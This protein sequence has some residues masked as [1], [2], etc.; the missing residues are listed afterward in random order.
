LKEYEG[1]LAFADRSSGFTQCSQNK[2]LE[3]VTYDQIATALT[4]KI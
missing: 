2:Q 4:G 1:A 3:E